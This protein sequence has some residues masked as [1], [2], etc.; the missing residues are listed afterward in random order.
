MALVRQLTNELAGQEYSS[1]GTD[2]ARSPVS[3]QQIECL[4]GVVEM[5]FLVAVLA[6]LLGG[7]SVIALGVSKVNSFL[8]GIRDLI[9]L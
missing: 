6:F 1:R 4:R 8:D 2:R 7:L 9:G 3:R 5:N